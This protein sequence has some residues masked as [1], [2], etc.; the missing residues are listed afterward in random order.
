M[1]KNQKHMKAKRLSAVMMLL[2][3]NYSGAWS[4]TENTKN[5]QHGVRG[6]PG[7]E[8]GAMLNSPSG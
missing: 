6:T 5:R 1:L 8:G 7:R 2:E 4:D 3:H